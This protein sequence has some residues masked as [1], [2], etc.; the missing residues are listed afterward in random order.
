MEKNKRS[1]QL[2]TTSELQMTVGLSQTTIIDNKG[3]HPGPDNIY[4]L[5]DGYDPSIDAEVE[6]VASISKDEARKLSKILNEFA[7]SEEEK[8]FGPV[9][10]TELKSLTLRQLMSI[11]SGDYSSI[12]N[13]EAKANEILNVVRSFTR[14]FSVSGTLE[15][16]NDMLNSERKT[17]CLKSCRFLTTHKELNAVHEVLSNLGYVVPVDAEE[18][19]LIT[20]I[21]AAQ[22]DVIAE[23]ENQTDR[24]NNPDSLVMDKSYFEN[25]IAIIEEDRKISIDLDVYSA[26]E[27]LIDSSYLCASM[28]AAFCKDK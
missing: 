10:F 14:N 15:L 8:D 6:C 20:I 24:M 2:K 28:M 3:R 19:G 16:A 18:S 26:Y 25:D 12:D 9:D 13:N 27:F 23:V 7:D 11:C 1:Y 21:E 17:E 5:I 4:F 22:K